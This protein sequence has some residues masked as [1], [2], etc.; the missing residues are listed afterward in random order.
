MASQDDGNVQE[1]TELPEHLTEV[2]PLA[3]AVLALSER[4]DVLYEEDDTQHEADSDDEPAGPPEAIVSV[5]RELSQ[6]ALK[7]AVALEQDEEALFDLDEWSQARELL[8]R[9]V[10]LPLSLVEVNELQTALEVARAFTFA[11]PETYNADVAIILAESGEREAATQ[12]L[13]AN[14]EQ[15]PDSFLTV[16]KSGQALEALGNAD[17]AEAAYRKAITL[18]KEDYEREEAVTQLAGFLED[19]GRE[20]EIEAP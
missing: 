17:G 10:E 13:E 18:A 19:M 15:Y 14:A 12:Q 16:I 6:A 2:V 5:L 3:E 9:L 20:D 7:L 1:P 4:L 8:P 11:A